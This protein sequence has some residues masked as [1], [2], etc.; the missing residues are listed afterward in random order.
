MGSESISGDDEGTPY[1]LLLQGINVGG[2]S[3]LPMTVLRDILTGLGFSQARTYLQSGN[4]VVTTSL[5]A[6]QVAAAAEKALGEALSRDVGVVVRTAA[7]LVGVVEHAPFDPAVDPTTKHVMFLRQASDAEKLGILP[8]ETMGSEHYWVSGTHVYLYLPSGMGR[9]K[10]S[11]WV[12]RRLA[13]TGSTARNWNTV[14]A[15]RD[16]TSGR[17]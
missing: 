5:T 17:R 6:A 15:L 13:G 7:Q 16:M 11:A 12:T 3:R 4:A 2:H 1:V 8:R 10:L 9:S 14:L